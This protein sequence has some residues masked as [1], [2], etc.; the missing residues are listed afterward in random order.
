MFAM[1]N[2]K[3]LLGATGLCL[4][5]SAAPTHRATAA[6]AESRSEVVSFHDLNL[7]SPPDQAILHH[8]LMAAANKVCLWA[9]GPGDT[10]DECRRDSF[11]TAWAQAQTFIADAKTR[12]LFGAATPA[13]AEPKA[14][15]A[16][17]SPTKAAPGR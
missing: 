14:L 17:A 3:F 5:L 1:N 2:R 7:V 15:V 16:S 12:S 11:R 9:E 10:M 8:R 4:V 6:D 13:W